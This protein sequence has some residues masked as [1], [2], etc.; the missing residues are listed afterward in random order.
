V[1]T[2]IVERVGRV[3]ALRPKGSARVLQIEVDPKLASGVIVGASVAI[4]GCCLTAVS[5]AD[6]RL[7]FE[8][9][10]ETLQR[11]ALGDRQ[12][13]DLV[14]VERALVAGGRLDGHIV[15]GHVDG[16]GRVVAFERRDQDVRLAVQC[17]PEIALYLVP[18]GSVTINGVSLTVVNANPEGFDVALIPHTLGETTLGQLRID[19]RVNLEVDIIGKYVHHYL[20]RRAPDPVP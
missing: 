15:Q 19:A 6:G 2:G 10:P 7:E 5:V 18:K 16:C 4:D 14:N 1:F 8:A 9:V 20:A 3:S 12:L 11:T 13:G 17:A